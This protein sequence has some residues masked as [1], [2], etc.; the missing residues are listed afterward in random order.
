MQPYVPAWCCRLARGRGWKDS[1]D[2][3]PRR[4]TQDQ[5][6]RQTRDAPRDLGPEGW[7]RS[8]ACSL[9]VCCLFLSACSEICLAA[10]QREQSPKVNSSS[11][12]VG[13]ACAVCYLEQECAR[14]GVA[15]AEAG[16]TGNPSVK[17][18]SLGRAGLWFLDNGGTNMAKPAFCKDP[19]QQCRELLSRWPC[20][21]GG[22]F[23]GRFR[24]QGK[25]Q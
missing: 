4:R 20:N 21:Q 16:G 9:F 17:A 22:Q 12:L 14:Q 2:R 19:S 24:H 1:E 15:G 7:R 5:G 25:R 23:R 10:G 13:K 18:P 3:H 11:I 6:G 8:Y